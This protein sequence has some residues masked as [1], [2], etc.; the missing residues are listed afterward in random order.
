[1][2][3]ENNHLDHTR[4]TKLRR[5]IFLLPESLNSAN[6]LAVEYCHF[7]ANYDA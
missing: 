6:V 7:A 5:V 1:M 4:T 3:G 2:Q